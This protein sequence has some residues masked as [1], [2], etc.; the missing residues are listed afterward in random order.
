MK[1]PLSPRLALPAAVAA[2][3]VLLMNPVAAAFAFAVAGILIL[4][5]ADYGRVPPPLRPESAPL[6]FKAPGGDPERMRVAA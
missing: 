5:V 3:V 2:F 1:S 4:L 6:D